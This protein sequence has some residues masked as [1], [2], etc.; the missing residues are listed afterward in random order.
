M[1]YL[2]HTSPRSRE[3]TPYRF[4]TSSFQLED[5]SAA[6]TPEAQ[7]RSLQTKLLEVTTQL[8]YEQAEREVLHHRLAEVE[9]RGEESV[10]MSRRK[11]EELV[12]LQEA[13][14]EALLKDKLEFQ[15]IYNKV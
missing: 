2:E 12:R 10:E 8:A 9:R 14:D 3:Q 4:P 15:H 13:L 5:D 6:T 11:D 7:I 1:L